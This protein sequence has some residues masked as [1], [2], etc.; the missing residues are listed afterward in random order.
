MAAKHSKQQGKQPVRQLPQS[1]I[2]VKTEQPSQVIPY[3]GHSPIQ[4][5]NRFTSL[6]SIVSQIHPNYQSALISSY[7]QFQVITPSPTASPISHTK[8]SPYFHR[9]SQTLFLIESCFNHCTNPVKIA[10]AYFPSNFHYMPSHPS[11]SLKYYRDILLETQSLETR[12]I[13]DRSDPNII[14]Y[15]SMYIKN[16]LSQ[17]KWVTHG[18]SISIVNS[19]VNFPTGSPPGGKSMVPLL[20]FFLPIS[21][22]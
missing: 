5:S 22:R 14:L 7:D 8:S 21:K 10:K 1:M 4:I 6:G 20:S 11:K 16:I 2:P 15:H 3:A 17:S 19:K 18:L 9:N 12:P 13:K